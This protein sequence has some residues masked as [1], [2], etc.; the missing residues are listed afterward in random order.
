MFV[1]MKRM[2]D[3][4][5]G[6]GLK[7]RIPAGWT[8]A[9]D[10]EIAHKA[11]EAGFADEIQGDATTTGA[12][13]MDAQSLTASIVKPDGEAA[14][15]DTLGRATRDPAALQP[16][17]APPPITADFAKFDHDGDGRPGGAVPRSSRREKKD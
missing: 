17:P 1:R 7:R 14:I 12:G 15:T 13:N 8:G 16:T 10:D 3:Y 6:S 2:H 5:D 4:I 11:I 9:L